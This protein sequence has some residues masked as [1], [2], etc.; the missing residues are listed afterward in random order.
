MLED[1]IKI[2]RK[3][4]A[5]V[6]EV[7]LDLISNFVGKSALKLGVPLFKISAYTPPQGMEDD[8]QPVRKWY[9]NNLADRGGL[10]IFHRHDLLHY[11]SKAQPDAVDYL[12]TESEEE[13]KQHEGWKD[14]E[15]EAVEI[16]GWVFPTNAVNASVVPTDFSATNIKISIFKWSKLIGEVYYDVVPEQRKMYYSHNRQ[17]K[18]SA[19]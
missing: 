7:D 10:A 19:D 9:R 2:K 12:V 1:G 17:A 11:L 14:P 8:Y 4:V 15:S 5:L 16:F 3:G 6:V 18:K 13:R